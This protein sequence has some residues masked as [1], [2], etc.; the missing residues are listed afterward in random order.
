Q[1]IHSTEMRSASIQRREIRERR[2]CR[3]TRVPVFVIDGQ[4][5]CPIILSA[6]NKPDD[7]ALS[8]DIHVTSGHEQRVEVR[9]HILPPVCPIVLAMID[10]AIGTRKECLADVL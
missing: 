8:I 1:N 6:C 7:L 10:T 2:G 9:V 4:T 5:N 3:P